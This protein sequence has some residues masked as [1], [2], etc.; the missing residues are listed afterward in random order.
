[1]RLLMTK[2]R[3][4]T[5]EMFLDLCK[6]MPNKHRKYVTNSQ[7]RYLFSKV[8]RPPLGVYLMVIL[9]VIHS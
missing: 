2:E 9:P 6:N 5:C 8:N 3:T 7:K 4:F 1:M